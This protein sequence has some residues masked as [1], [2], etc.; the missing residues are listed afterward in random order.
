MTSPKIFSLF[1]RSNVA[2]RKIDKKF[3]I[4]KESKEEEAT[5]FT[6]GGRRL[7]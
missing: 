6:E 7:K 3:C 5:Q 1:F 2:D 4:S